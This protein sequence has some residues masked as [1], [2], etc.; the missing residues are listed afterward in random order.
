MPK[1]TP[2]EKVDWNV[3]WAELHQAIGAAVS[4]WSSLEHALAKAFATTLGLPLDRAER[5]FFTLYTFN[6]K[7]GLL[8]EAIQSNPIEKGI[9]AT[10][11]SIFKSA[12]KKAERYAPTRN[13]IAHSRPVIAAKG[14]I[15][16]GGVIAPNFMSD[17][18]KATLDQTITVKAINEARDSFRIL[19]RLV[20]QA[21]EEQDPASL[22]KLLQ[23]VRSLAPIPYSD[24]LG[25]RAA[26]THKPSP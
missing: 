15:V 13:K 9:E 26:S 8:R 22:D 6:A 14:S 25:L 5:M 10:R 7:R 4:A 24:S 2:R 20:K 23:Q 17:D 11:L 3:K 21:C 18:V 1:E 16:L 12:C 19:A